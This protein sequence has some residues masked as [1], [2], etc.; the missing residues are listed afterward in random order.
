MRFVLSVFLLTAACCSVAAETVATKADTPIS[1]DQL[2]N[3]AVQKLIE[4]A[5]ADYPFFAVLSEDVPGFRKN[6]ETKTA[7]SQLLSAKDNH[8]NLAL[9]TG[10]TMALEQTDFYLSK[11]DDSDANRYVAALSKLML[12]GSTDKEVCELMLPGT[13][14][15][16]DEKMSAD[17]ETRMA[18]IFIDTLLPAV[19]GVITSGDKG[20]V[21]TLS[22]K[23]LESLVLP[24]ILL[25][26]EKHGPDA[27]KNLSSLDDPNLD[28]TKRCESMAWMMQSIVA[29]PEKDRAMLARTLFSKN[30]RNAADFE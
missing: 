21:K 11:S 8:K 6:W 12:I 24:V 29:Q 9:I 23:E 28:S 27:V 7:I 3:K 1:S 18:P 4:K 26:A 17:L 19:N 30:G 25:M 5:V 2:P 15:K 20:E 16:L 10:I 22:K 13:K 14:P